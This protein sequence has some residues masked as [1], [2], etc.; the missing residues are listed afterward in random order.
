[1]LPLNQKATEE[2]TSSHTVV[3]TAIGEREPLVCV[4][5]HTH[6]GTHTDGMIT[7]P[8]LITDCLSVSSSCLDSFDVLWECF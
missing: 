1:M 8:Y 3:P 6:A 7:K 2:L 4:T 5:W